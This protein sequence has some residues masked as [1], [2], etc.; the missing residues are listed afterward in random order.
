MSKQSRR[1]SSMSQSTH[2][3]TEGAKPN[4]KEMQNRFHE[5][6]K[7]GNIEELARMIGLG[8]NVDSTVEDKSTALHFAAYENQIET[9][10]YL[11]DMNASVNAKNERGL[12]PLHIAASEGN[13][14][15]VCV[16]IESGA[17][18]NTRDTQNVFF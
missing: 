11:I 1:Y 4:K 3:L 2:S 16:L 8:V 14:L 9:I 10:R 6:A 18:P 13:D 5:A 15:A 17:N 12:T 7:N